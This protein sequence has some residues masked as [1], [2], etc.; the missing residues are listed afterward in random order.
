MVGVEARLS[1]NDTL[2]DVMMT[3]QITGAS[4]NSLF[5]RERSRHWI[6]S[7]GVRGRLGL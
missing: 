2:A 4:W 3:D 7:S 5:E 6:V 1:I